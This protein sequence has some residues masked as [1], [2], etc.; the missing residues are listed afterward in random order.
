MSREVESSAGKHRK[1]L[2]VVLAVT[3]TYMVIEVIAGVLTRSLAL[4]ADAGH[5]LTDVFGLGLALFAIWFG[6]RGAT[7]Q[8]T[9][10]YYRAEI[11]AATVNALV[12]FGI[13]GYI[14]FEAWKRFQDPPDV[15]SGPMMIVATIGL[16][17]NIFGAFLLF[18]AS[19]ES[20]N[21]RGAFFEVVS[22]M[23][24]S[25]GVIV[26]GAIIYFT[27]WPYA[28]PLISVGI[29]LFILPR[30][31]NLLREAVGVLLEGTPS[32]INLA[33]LEQQLLAVPAVTKVHDLHVWS[34][35]SGVNALSAHLVV[36]QR[37][38]QDAVLEQVNAT[39][40]EQFKI[41]HTTIQIEIADRQPQE[42]A[43]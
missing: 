23:L 16:G 19:G 35:T 36:G 14:L 2:M 31:W 25:I 11:L 30:T 39:L 7:P 22:D 18:K 26:A 28:D 12:L 41:E 1:R 3:S 32:D 24:G 20:L 8:R 37:V 17:I 15:E 21:M 27:G 6:A 43:V 10:G 5:M 9:Y 4:I 38:D 13:S 29:G 40:R 34:L 42:A 33:S